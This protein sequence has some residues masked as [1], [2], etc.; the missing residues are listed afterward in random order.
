MFYEQK[1]YLVST[2]GF[3]ALFIPGVVPKIAGL[4][5]IVL[6]YGILRMRYRNRRI[7]MFKQ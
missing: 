2:I 1:P 3:G 4:V 6:S 7:G 5:L